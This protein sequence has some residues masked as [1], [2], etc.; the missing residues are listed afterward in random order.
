MR[1]K[2]SKIEIEKYASPGVY[3]VEVIRWQ[4][5]FCRLLVPSL[6]PSMGHR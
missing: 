6:V 1:I 5:K 2:F 3:F 4:M